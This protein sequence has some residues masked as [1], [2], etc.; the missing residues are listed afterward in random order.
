MKMK[1]G[2]IEYL[3]TFNNNMNMKQIIKLCLI[4][5]LMIP[6]MLLLGQDG[7]RPN[8]R[9]GGIDVEVAKKRFIENKLDSNR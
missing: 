6:G 3:K 7:K 2:L 9:Q 5:F 4:G 8:G 1:N